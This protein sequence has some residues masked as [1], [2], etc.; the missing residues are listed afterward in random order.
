VV[1]ERVAA[2]DRARAGY[3]RRHHDPDGEP[4][5]RTAEK[6]ANAPDA[7]IVPHAEPMGPTRGHR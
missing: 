7:S 5:H 1:E 2:E 3:G 6:T 4:E